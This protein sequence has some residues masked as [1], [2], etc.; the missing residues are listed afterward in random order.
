MTHHANKFLAKFERMKWN[1]IAFSSS[2]FSV[3]RF[4]VERF[5]GSLLDVS[6]AGSG[7]CNAWCVCVLQAGYDGRQHSRRRGLKLLRWGDKRRERIRASVETTN[8]RTVT[9]GFGQF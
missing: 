3:E 5:P 9:F 4:S 8:M 1:T 6:T 2:R 7:A